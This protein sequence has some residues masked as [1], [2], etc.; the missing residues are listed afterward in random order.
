MDEVFEPDL[1]L[2]VAPQGTGQMESRNGT[3]C[4]FGDERFS[5]L[6]SWAQEGDTVSDIL[7]RLVDSERQRREDAK[8]LAPPEPKNKKEMVLHRVFHRFSLQLAAVESGIPFAQLL[9][10]MEVPKFRLEVEM[11]RNAYVDRMEQWLLD[12][13]KARK[14]SMAA[15]Q[16]ATNFLAANN[17][18]WGRTRVETIKQ[19]VAP[20]F[21]IF[22]AVL[23][24]E[25]TSAD[26][27]ERILQKTADMYEVRNAG[28]F[29]F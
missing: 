11:H 16:G 1:S 26:Q 25:L 13:V 2:A 10:W 7:R 14:P 9:K 17:E 6:C 29:S 23:K 12:H 19:A 22:G 15:I 28:K 21:K 27:T 8:W 3:T 18:K 20:L 24:A 4:R 5:L